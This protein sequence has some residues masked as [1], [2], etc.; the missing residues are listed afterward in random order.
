MNELQQVLV[1]FAVV[2]ILAMYL[3]QKIKQKN[4]NQSQHQDADKDST[5]SATVNADLADSRHQ[6]SQALNNLG[7]PHISVN[8]TTHQRLMVEEP[9]PENQIRLAFDDEHESTQPQQNADHLDNNQQPDAAGQTEVQAMAV[10][11]AQEAPAATD[12]LAPAATPAEAAQPK[13]QEKQPSEVFALIVMSTEHSFNLAK[14]KQA[15]S[16]IGLVANDLGIYVKKDS[17]NHD[18]IKVA[19][20]LEPGVFPFDDDASFTTHGVVFILELPCTVG[21]SD[22]MHEMIMMARKLSQRLNG[23]IYNVERQLIKESELLSM[24][25]AASRFDGK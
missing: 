12:A 19:N 7:E 18:L 23:R 22:I 15:L 17:M 20:L 25:E 4:Q 6:A 24:R 5:E 11:S 8:S 9:V 2:V 1:V 13:A 14:I 3:L 10:D 21:A 16:G